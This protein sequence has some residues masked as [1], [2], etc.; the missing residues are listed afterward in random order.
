M[1]NS[2]T[3]EDD[4][5]TIYIPSYF[6]SDTLSDI[7]SEVSKKWGEG[8]SLDDITIRADYI[9]TECITYDCYDPGDWTNYLVIE[10]KL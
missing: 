5:N 1:K 2:Y 6:G 8:V 9:H 4:E 7:L 3:P 10:R